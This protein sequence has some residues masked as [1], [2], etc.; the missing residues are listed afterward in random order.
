MDI[1]LLPD[2]QIVDLNSFNDQYATNKIKLLLHAKTVE[3]LKII[4]DDIYAEGFEDGCNEGEN[5]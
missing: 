4:V 3:E 1:S 5:S 2:Q